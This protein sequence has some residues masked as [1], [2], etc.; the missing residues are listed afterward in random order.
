[1]NVEAR[2]NGLELLPNGSKS[3]YR[4]YDQQVY[5]WNLYQQGGNTAA[6]PGTSNHGWGLAVDLATPAMRAL[7]DRIGAPYGWSKAWSDAPGE[8]WH[9][10]YSEGAYHGPDPGPTG[11]PAPLKW[12]AKGFRVLGL[13][14]RLRDCGWLARPYWNFNK[15][16]HGAVIAFQKRHKL[17]PDG[18]VGPTTD[19]TLAEAS[20]WC[21]K[22][23]KKEGHP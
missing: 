19:K 13:S 8:W 7:L 23:H 2:K 12:G 10:K 20:A 15:P 17:S 18:I 21:K 5:F 9:I 6:R 3:S 1:M 16:V 14:S 22:H 11:G 4:T